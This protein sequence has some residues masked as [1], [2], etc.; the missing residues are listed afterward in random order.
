[1]A[2]I[3]NWAVVV[4]PAKHRYQAPEQC[5]HFLT[6][7][8]F[9]HPRFV[10]GEVIT[11]TSITGKREGKVVTLSDSEYELGAPAA[12]YEKFFPNAKERCLSSLRE[13]MKP[14]AGLLKQA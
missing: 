12:D 9:D 8:V 5:R 13:L 14:T 2:R 3:E 10:D 1:M 6:G 7:N 11:S 4:D